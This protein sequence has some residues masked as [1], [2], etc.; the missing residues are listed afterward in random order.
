MVAVVVEVEVVEVAVS[1]EGVAEVA[2][3]MLGVMVIEE[4][5]EAREEGFTWPGRS[6]P[7]SDEEEVSFWMVDEQ[8]P[9]SRSSLMKYGPQ[10]RERT[11]EL[12]GM[13]WPSIAT[14]SISARSRRLIAR[15]PSSTAAFGSGRPPRDEVLL[16]TEGARTG[17][18]MEG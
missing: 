15:I 13:R 9:L 12:T 6:V 7:P 4:L 5:R 14:R 11:W 1:E 17:A 2:V 18:L 16:M 8:A 10:R 3:V